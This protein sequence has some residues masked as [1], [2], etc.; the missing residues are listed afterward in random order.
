MRLPDTRRSVSRTARTAEGPSRL[1]SLITRIRTPGWRRNRAVRQLLALALVVTAAVIAL[2]STRNTDPWAV[3]LNRSVTAGT[4]LTGED[5][6]LVRVPARLLPEGALDSVDGGVGRIIVTSADPGQILTETLLV[7]PGMTARL[8]DV[9][10]SAPSRGGPTLV[11]LRLADPTVI[12]FLMHGDTVT[13]LTAA[14]GD[15]PAPDTPGPGVEPGF[16]VIA[17]GARVVLA[18]APGDGRGQGAATVLLALPEQDAGKVA[19][20]S[21]GSPVTVVLTGS[22]ARGLG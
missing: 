2:S 9:P 16:R 14:G 15:A 7:G 11:P 5:L 10:E 22:R 3:V 1:D 4:E 19:A 13:V 12:P 20:L 21:L 6:D 18:G 8:I 17:E